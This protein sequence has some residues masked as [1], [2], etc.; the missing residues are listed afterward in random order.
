MAKERSRREISPPAH[1]QVYETKIPDMRSLVVM[2]GETPPLRD[3]AENLTQGEKLPVINNKDEIGI[4]KQ[5][6]ECINNINGIT[7]T[8]RAQLVEITLNQCYCQQL[9]NR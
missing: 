4:N 5:S 9:N 3:P 2:N 8:Q 7:S 6:S 1:L